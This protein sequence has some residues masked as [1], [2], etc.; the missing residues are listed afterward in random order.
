MNVSKLD[1]LK[2]GSISETRKRFEPLQSGN[3]RTS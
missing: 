2:L 1:R 3:V